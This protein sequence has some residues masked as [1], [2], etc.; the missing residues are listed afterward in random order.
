MV[1]NRSSLVICLNTMVCISRRLNDSDG[2][3]FML[4]R[5]P[6]PPPKTYP[7]N[8]NPYQKDC[9]QYHSTTTT[10]RIVPCT[11]REQGDWLL[12]EI[13]SIAPGAA[14]TAADNHSSLNPGAI[15][16]SDQLLHSWPL[17]RPLWYT[18]EDDEIVLVDKNF[19]SW[20]KNCPSNFVLTFCLF[21]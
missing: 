9:S 7:A 2:H 19:V 21:S 12:F 14:G 10:Q 1:K 18:F 20:L 17:L 13:N 8:P 15:Y 6:R 11:T 16:L 3:S 4:R 5:R